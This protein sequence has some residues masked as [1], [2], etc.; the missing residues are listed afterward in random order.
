MLIS[1][2]MDDFV[3]FMN[4][5]KKIPADIKELAR[6]QPKSKM[7]PED[8]T[9][10]LLSHDKTSRDEALFLTDEEKKWFLKMKSQ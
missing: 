7:Q 4:S 5:V 1:T 2:L 8:V 3:K 6:Y 9:E 10:L